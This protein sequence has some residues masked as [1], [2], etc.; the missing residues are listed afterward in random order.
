MLNSLAAVIGNLLGGYLFDR[1][2][3]FKTIVIGVT[4]NIVTLGLLVFWHDWWPYVILLTIIGF[5]GGVV[6]LRCMH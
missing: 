1:I 4:L 5:S 2:G 3:G 6:F